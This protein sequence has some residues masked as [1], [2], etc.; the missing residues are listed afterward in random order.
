MDDEAKAWALGLEIRGNSVS[1]TNVASIMAFAAEVRRDER[2]RALAAISTRQRVVPSH[3]MEVF[4]EGYKAGIL[5]KN[6]AIRAL[7]DAPGGPDPTVALA[8]LLKWAW[9]R[10][11]DV[12]G[13]SFFEKATELGFFTLQYTNKYDLFIT[14][15]GLAALALAEAP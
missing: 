3:M 15:L 5:D 7:S 14:D 8:R 2:E 12:S 4:S 13:Q 1:T 10:Q 11:E 9:E 6:C